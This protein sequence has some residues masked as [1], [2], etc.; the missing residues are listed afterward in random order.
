[1]YDIH[2]ADGDTRQ[3]GLVDIAIKNENNIQN[4]EYAIVIKNKPSGNHVIEQNCDTS[5][6]HSDDLLDSEYDRL[7]HGRPCS[8]NDSSN[9]YDSALGFREECDATYNTTDYRRIDKGDDSVYDHT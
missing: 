7:N 8:N 1:M 5:G 4:N 2:T 6:G 9:P 3:F